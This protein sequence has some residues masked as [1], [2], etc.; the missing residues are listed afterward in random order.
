MII[1]HL[2]P[3][4]FEWL[5]VM[6]SYSDS[7][8][9]GSPVSW[10]HSKPVEGVSYG[11]GN[12][13][14]AAIECENYGNQAA[15]IHGRRFSLVSARQTDNSAIVRQLGT[16]KERCKLTFATELVLA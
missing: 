1:H 12:G 13:S 2:A 10:T 11:R 6:A 7:S 9:P 14:L 3:L 5:S 8:K 15:N 4:S 16:S